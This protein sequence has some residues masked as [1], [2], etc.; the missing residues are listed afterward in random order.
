MVSSPPSI[1]RPSSR[2]ERLL[3][4]T[5]RRDETRCTHGA[6][7]S[8]PRSSSSD[9]GDDDDDDLFQSAILSRY[10]S[11]RNSAASALGHSQPA[12]SYY[13]PDQNEHASYSRLLRS[14]SY[15]GSSRSAQS[16]PKSSPRPAYIQEKQVELSRHHDSAPHEAVLRNRL[17]SVMHSMRVDK[18]R[19]LVDVSPRERLHEHPILIHTKSGHQLGALPVGRLVGTVAKLLHGS[20]RHAHPTHRRMSVKCLREMR[21]HGL[22]MGPCEL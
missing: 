15:P 3:W 4:D 10:S 11:R 22:P 5:L 2:S 12:N 16:D 19:D 17:D 20:C 1:P 14:S 18:E 9:C 6:H 8:R 7:S 21:F 13:I